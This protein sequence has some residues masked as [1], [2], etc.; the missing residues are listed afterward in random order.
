MTDGGM[1][2]AKKQGA[3]VEV[4]RHGEAQPNGSSVRMHSTGGSV[5]VHSH[6][7]FSNAK[8]KCHTFYSLGGGSLPG[9][10]PCLHCR[11]PR[12]VVVQEYWIDVMGLDWI[13]TYFGQE[14]D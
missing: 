8:A 10:V 14:E 7:A 11:R 1:R 5:A 9:S 6:M 2:L 3:D 13:R 4:D 12:W